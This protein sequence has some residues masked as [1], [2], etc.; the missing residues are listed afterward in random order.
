M[1]RLSHQVSFTSTADEL[2]KAR[3]L[4]RRSEREEW[5]QQRLRVMMK[6]ACQGRTFNANSPHMAAPNAVTLR[7]SSCTSWKNA[8]T[9]SSPERL[10]CRSSR[11]ALP[12]VV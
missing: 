5:I 1:P 7:Y 6:M 3:R 10:S 2:V 11:R 4:Q 9:A 12:A 8:R